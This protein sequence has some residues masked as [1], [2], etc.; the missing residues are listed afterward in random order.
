MSHTNENGVDVF[1][2]I[3]R[4]LGLSGSGLVA[5]I[6]CYSDASGSSD[7]SNIAVGAYVSTV[8]RWNRFEPLWKA[9]LEIE[10]V[11]YFRRSQ[12]EPPFHGE[13]AKLGWTKQ[14]QIPLVRLLQTI[15]KA[16]TIK[17]VAK[18]VRN[19]AFAEMMPLK[20]KKMYGGPF[21]WCVLLNLVDL[22]LWARRADNWIN[23]VF[24]A[25]DEG[26][27]QINTA[28]Q[29]LYGD[30][31]SRELLRIASW[32]FAPKKGPNA[33]VQLQAADFIAFESY[34]DI[35]NHLAPLRRSAMRVCRGSI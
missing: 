5:L 19:K 3:C 18:A 27:G 16:H 31:R 6:E 10:H 29:E 4:G 34:K 17:G 22:G 30:E 21:G 28:I 23:Y 13:F 12:M 24:E 7:Q 15:I 8:D 35:V 25:G 33:V 14:D 1:N 11:E 9:Q 26:Q 20:I 2:G 32:S